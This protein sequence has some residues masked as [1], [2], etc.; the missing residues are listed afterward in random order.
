MIKPLSE[1]LAK[2]QKGSYAIGAFNTSNLEITLAI[3]RA[4]AMA[5]LTG[6]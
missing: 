1:M 2:A 5:W 3:A 6:W 4:A